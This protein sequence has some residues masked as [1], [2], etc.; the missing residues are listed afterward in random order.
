MSFHHSRLYEV[1]EFIS[2]RKVLQSL[3]LQHGCVFFCN[4]DHRQINKAAFK[5]LDSPFGDSLET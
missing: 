2:D 4:H 1:V 3:Q 5:Q